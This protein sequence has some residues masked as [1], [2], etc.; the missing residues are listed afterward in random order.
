LPLISAKAVLASRALTPM[1]SAPVA[2]FTSAQRSL[3]DARVS[4]EPIRRGSS[5]LLV[6]LNSSTRSDSD[7]SGS[8]P[9]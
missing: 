5:D 6:M 1:R 7:G 4:S 3:I 9:P 8:V 2:N